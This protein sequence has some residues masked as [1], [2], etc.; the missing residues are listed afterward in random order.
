M[1][2][3]LWI[4]VN[5][6]C[7]SSEILIFFFNRHNRAEVAF[8]ALKQQIYS[9]EPCILTVLHPAL[10]SF[11]PIIDKK[12]DQPSTAQETSQADILLS[13]LITNAATENTIVLRR[14]Y[15]KFVTEYVQMLGLNS[16]SHLSHLISLVSQYLEVFD[17]PE[18]ESRLNAVTLLQAV[19]QNTWPRIQGHSDTIVKTLLKLIQDV[20]N[21]KSNVSQN[22]K[23]KLK[24]EAVQCLEL[25]IEVCPET[26][27]SLSMISQS[28]H[29]KG[30]AKELE[31][32]F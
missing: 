8:A 31:G 26:K 16:V 3:L 2:N 14:L 25:V 23:D 27:E 21:E 7:N 6:V 19:I 4:H 24:T 9:R 12:P 18:E 5:F 22:V 30:I 13:L 17:G 10:L 28:P 29:L 15:S 11:L 32:L 20:V 1:Y